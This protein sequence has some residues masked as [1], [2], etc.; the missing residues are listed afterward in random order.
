MGTAV[1]AGGLELSPLAAGQE[2]RIE[3]VRLVRD[4]PGY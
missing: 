3:V 4:R 2:V 1:R